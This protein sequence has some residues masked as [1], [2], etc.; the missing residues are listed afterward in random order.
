MVLGF[1]DAPITRLPIY[2]QYLKY[3]ARVEGVVA[4]TNTLIRRKMVL[5]CKDIL[6]ITHAGEDD[7]I[8]RHIAMKGLKI[9]TIPERLCYHDR[10]PYETHRSAYERSG[11][12]AANRYPLIFGTRVALNSL[13]GTVKAWC[14]FSAET[15]IFSLELLLFLTKLWSH[16]L[17]G[18][19]KGSFARDVRKDGGMYPKATV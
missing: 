12:S 7:V 5:E 15:G 11:E 18:F 2:D 10:D 17:T 19:L 16:Y 4:F 9:V 14:R 3:R 8:A 6:R 1:A 13:R